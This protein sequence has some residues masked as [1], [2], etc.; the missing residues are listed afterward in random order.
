M[1]HQHGE[2][3]SVGVSVA[4][5][6]TMAEPRFKGNSPADIDYIALRRLCVNKA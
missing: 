4:I 1:V 5:G 2:T 6:S 3:A